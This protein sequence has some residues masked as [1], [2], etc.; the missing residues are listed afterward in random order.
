M[1]VV[2]VHGCWRE[3]IGNRNKSEIEIDLSIWRE[4]IG[5]RNRLVTLSPSIDESTATMNDD[6][7][8]GN[9]K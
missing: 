8:G 4:E 3:E 7:D 5:N 2:V 1:V 9:S 6:V